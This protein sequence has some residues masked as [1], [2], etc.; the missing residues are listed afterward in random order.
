MARVEDDYIQAF[1]GG[2]QSVWQRDRWYARIGLPESGSGFRYTPRQVAGLP[3]F[4]I[5]DLIDYFAAVRKE[6]L[7][8][9]D[10]LS[11]V[12]LDARPA[13]TRW[14]ERTVG[15]MLGHLV[16]EQSQHLGQIAY[17]RG[18]QRGQE[19]PFSWPNA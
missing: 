16:V 9:L 8:Y 11:A 2:E 18:L 15:W 12:D 10:G 4:D 3:T 5:G 1:A 7:R 19:T 13:H 14:P 17:L 6:T